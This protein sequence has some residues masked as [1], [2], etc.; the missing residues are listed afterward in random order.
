MR[1]RRLPSR[2]SAGRVESWPPGSARESSFA[3]CLTLAV[4]LHLL[5]VSLVGT[6]PGTGSRHGAGGA[7]PLQ[8]VLEGARA[9]ARAASTTATGRRPAAAEL[10]IAMAPR[11]TGPAV[12]PAPPLPQAPA[13]ARTTA[14]A[15]A[16]RVTPAP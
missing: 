7:P 3:Q 10:L 2:T 16:A 9:P 12:E 1:I 15:D 5:V 11:P 14:A 6:A 13:P 8:V 4:L